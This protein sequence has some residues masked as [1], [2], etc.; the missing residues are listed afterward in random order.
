V[1]VAREIFPDAT[2][3]HL[4]GG[5]PDGKAKRDPLKEEHLWNY[6]ENGKIIR[7]GSNRPDFSIAVARNVVEVLRGN[8]YDSDGAGNPTDREA[9]AHDRI[10]AKTPGEKMVMLEKQGP[11][12]TEQEFRKNAREAC[13]DAFTE[14]REDWER[15]GELNKPASKIPEN[16]D[17]PDSAR[18]A[19]D[20]RKKFK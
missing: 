5:N 11:G 9:T 18:R 4:F 6:D 2:V 7:Q 15:R 14:L 3:G 12:M 17:G 20:Q 8:S 16:Y 13:R 1:K 19:R 10:K